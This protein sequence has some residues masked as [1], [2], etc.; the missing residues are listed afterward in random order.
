VGPRHETVQLL[1]VS[2]ESGSV[3]PTF[4][5]EALET[6]FNFSLARS[7]ESFWH[8]AQNCHFFLPQRSWPNSNLLN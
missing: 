4:D 8:L 5:Y 1:R 3:L 6:E 7:G 2:F